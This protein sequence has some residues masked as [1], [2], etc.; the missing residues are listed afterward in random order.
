MQPNFDKSRLVRTI[1]VCFESVH[2]R[3]G[4]V[5]RTQWKRFN[6]ESLHEKSNTAKLLNAC[7]IQV[8]PGQ[9][10]DPTELVGK[11][12]TLIVGH[13]VKGTRTFANVIGFAKLGQGATPVVPEHR[14]NEPMPRWMLPQNAD[15][16]L[17]SLV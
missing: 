9:E 15:D 6:G 7:G 14:P 17:L 5:R 8:Q 12:L 11:N 1:G 10:F 3:L 2:E 13:E 16:A 4:G